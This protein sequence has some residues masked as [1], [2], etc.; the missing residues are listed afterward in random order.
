MLD[1]A[2][3]AQS[4]AA[5]IMQDLVRPPPCH[6][7]KSDKTAERNKSKS[8]S[9]KPPLDPNREGYR[10][11]KPYTRDVGACPKCG[12]L[13]HWAKDCKEIVKELN[14]TADGKAMLVR[15][16]NSNNLPTD[17]SEDAPS[18]S[19]VMVCADHVTSSARLSPLSSAVASSIASTRVAAEAREPRAR[20]GASAA[21]PTP[22][23]GALRRRRGV[24]IG[25]R[26]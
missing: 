4:I 5:V 11:G 15:I 26:A 21:A 16:T 25:A 24:A 6:P 18:A 19:V 3:H 22:R 20:G 8:K 10:N 23:A 13:D 17:A 9:D 2:D 7:T 14:K 1:A 12:K